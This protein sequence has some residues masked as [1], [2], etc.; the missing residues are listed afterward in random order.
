MNRV[1]SATAPARVALV[2]GAGGGIG[3]AVARRLARDGVAVCVGYR[4]DS[5]AAKRTR[6]DCE[7]A[8]APAFTCKADVA[9]D[10]DCRRM[11]A[12]TLQHYGRLDVVVY[13]DLYQRRRPVLAKDRVL[14]VTGIVSDDEF[15]GGCSMV[16]DAVEELVEVHECLA[17]HLLLEV[18]ATAARNGLVARLQQELDRLRGGSGDRENATPVNFSEEERLRVVLHKKDDEARRVRSGLHALLSKVT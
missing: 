15:S 1:T 7:A 5:A 9:E 2:T 12:G 13:S 16:A 8:G 10:D 11:V 6:A 14:V 3:G 17:R 4:G 18:E